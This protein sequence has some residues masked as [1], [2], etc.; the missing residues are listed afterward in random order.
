MKTVIDNKIVFNSEVRCSIC[1]RLG[2]FDLTSRFLCPEH[3]RSE[4]SVD[5]NAFL[6]PAIQRM[7]A[8]QRLAA[9]NDLNDSDLAM[10]LMKD[11][12]DVV[13]H[14][15]AFLLGQR[16]KERNLEDSDLTLEWLCKGCF[17]KSILVRHEVALA[18]ANFKGEKSLLFLSRLHLDQVQEVRDSAEYALHQLFS[19]K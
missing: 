15:A 7:N 16:G 11:E 18:L 4:I 6:N 3:I 10:A 14:E 2:A 8:P 19:D 13:R 9:L 17:D 5:Y 12:S 1:G